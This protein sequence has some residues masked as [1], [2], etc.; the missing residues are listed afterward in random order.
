[1][2]SLL[3]Q[4]LAM[5][6]LVSV[7]ASGVRRSGQAER[8]TD[9]SQ[10]YVDGSHNS[11]YDHQKLFGGRKG[12]GESDTPQPEQAKQQLSQIFHMIDTD[13]DELVSREELKKWIENSIK[14]VD[15]TDSSDRFE[16]TD[17]NKDGKTT[18][19]EVLR[20]NFDV[21]HEN[22]LD[23]D[24]DQKLLREDKLMFAAA[25]INQD[26]SLSIDEFYAFSYPESTERMYD[27]IIKIVLLEK[28]TNNDGKIDSTEFSE[29]S[30]DKER[31]SEDKEKFAEYDKN[32]DGVLTGE[33]ILAMHRP[34][35]E[36]IAADEVEHL[37]NSCDRDHDG[38]LSEAEVLENYDVFVGSEATDYGDHLENIANLRDEL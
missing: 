15:K 6:C 25:D 23:K 29:E 16:E 35:N 28:D 31:L 38:F 26:E 2:L 22:E 7:A 32:D 27:T 37:I 30:D 1:M 5:A 10:H 21:D 4:L 11:Q 36:Q 14:K 12:V 13:Q 9:G 8:E 18:W 34:T 17:R 3:L 33:E 24:D 19:L 20:D